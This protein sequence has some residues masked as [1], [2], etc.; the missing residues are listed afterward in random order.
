MQTA[1]GGPLRFQRRLTMARSM[2]RL[3]DFL[4]KHEEL[5]RRSFLLAVLLALP[6]IVVLRWKVG[7]EDADI[8]WHLRTGDLRR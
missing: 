1:A 8:R 2:T 3:K 4:S 7:L 5:F 6:A